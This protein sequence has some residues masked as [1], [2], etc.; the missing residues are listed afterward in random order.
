MAKDVL[1]VLDEAW[2]DLHTTPTCRRSSLTGQMLDAR[3][4]VSDLMSGASS[5]VRAYRNGHLCDAD[6]EWLESALAACRGM[7]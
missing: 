2:A 5:T 4:S 6:I 7:A 1:E 3:L